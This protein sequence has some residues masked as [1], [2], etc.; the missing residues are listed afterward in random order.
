MQKYWR[1]KIDTGENAH[2]PPLENTAS[3]HFL[4]HESKLKFM[5]E[6]K[7]HIVFYETRLEMGENCAE[8]L[9]KISIHFY[10]FSLSRDFFG[11]QF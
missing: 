2:H 7:G 4:L 6:E 11:Q 5:Q 9:C 10:V 8:E 3:V 1:A